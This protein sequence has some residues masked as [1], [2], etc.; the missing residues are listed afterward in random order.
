MARVI[1][2][3]KGSPKHGTVLNKPNFAEPDAAETGLT[4]K[5]LAWWHWAKEMCEAMGILDQSDEEYLLYAARSVT[6]YEIC[7]R[8]MMDD[9]ITFMNDRGVYVRNPAATTLKEC[10][11][12]LDKVYDRLGLNPAARNKLLEGREAPK[13]NDPLAELMGS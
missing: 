12:H 13:A 11:D 6:L 7:W 5:G 1:Q 8:S 4:G 10:R 3:G 9:G 2:P